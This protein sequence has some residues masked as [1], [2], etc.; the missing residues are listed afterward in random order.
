MAELLEQKSMLERLDDEL[1]IGPELFGCE[2]DTRGAFVGSH[3]WVYLGPLDDVVDWFKASFDMTEE[4][5][6][7]EPRIGERGEWKNFK[8]ANRAIFNRVTEAPDWESGWRRHLGS[9]LLRDESSAELAVPGETLEDVLSLLAGYYAGVRD[10]VP[11]LEEKILQ[12]RWETATK[13]GK[14]YVS[15]SAWVGRAKNNG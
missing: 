5:H 11:S 6:R 3:R 12:R 15:C 1:A 2:S 4:H 13:W 8:V 10:G 14:T 9:C 7:S